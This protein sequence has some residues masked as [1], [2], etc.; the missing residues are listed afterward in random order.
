MECLAKHAIWEGRDAC[1]FIFGQI[2]ACSYRHLKCASPRSP[3]FDTTL[4]VF[5]HTSAV[6]QKKVKMEE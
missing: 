5:A 1:W 3:R 4:P 2:R 6:L